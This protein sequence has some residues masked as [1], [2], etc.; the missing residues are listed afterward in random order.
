MPFVESIRSARELYGA[1]PVLLEEGRDRIGRPAC[2][3]VGHL[4]HL[5]HLLAPPL[6]SRG[7]LAAIG[8]HVTGLVPQTNHRAPPVVFVPKRA[9]AGRAQPQEPRLDPRLDPEPTTSRH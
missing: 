1:A 3:A 6:V 4:D 2:R 7:L 8:L 9:Q 5:G